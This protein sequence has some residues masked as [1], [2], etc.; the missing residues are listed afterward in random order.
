MLSRA[1]WFYS[2]VYFGL[3]LV[4]FFILIVPFLCDFDS[5]FSSRLFQTLWSFLG[6][7]FSHLL[8]GH[9]PPGCPQEA[10]CM[11]I[12]YVGA[13]RRLL[14]F[15]FLQSSQGLLTKASETVGSE[16]LRFLLPVFPTRRAKPAVFGGITLRKELKDPGPTEI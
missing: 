13:S 8:L 16:G 12:F 5:T 9:L 6:K 15:H 11:F 2:L 1:S 14:A 10:T 3:D 4:C 7:V